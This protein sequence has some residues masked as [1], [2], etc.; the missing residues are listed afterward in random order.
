MTALISGS[1]RNLAFLLSGAQS[2]HSAAKPFWEASPLTRTKSIAKDKRIAWRRSSDTG[3]FLVGRQVLFPARPS[4]TGRRRNGLNELV[5]ASVAKRNSSLDLWSICRRIWTSRWKSYTRPC[6]VCAWT[7]SASHLK[8]LIER[9]ACR[10]G[11]QQHKPHS[12][13]MVDYTFG[14]TE[15]RQAG[16]STS[17]EAPKGYNGTSSNGMMV[18]LEITVTQRG[19]LSPK[20]KNKRISVCCTGQPP[21]NVWIVGEATSHIR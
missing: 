14:G 5:C 12:Q 11:K 3:S 16:S 17:E 15:T 6:Q 9:V 7:A 10:I 21:V 4:S 19:L 2:K 20:K 13:M 8:T 1:P 18:A